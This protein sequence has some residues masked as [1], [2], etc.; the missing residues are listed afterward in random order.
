MFQW[1]FSFFGKSYKF[2]T[3]HPKKRCI[4]TYWNGH[5]LIKADP[6]PIYKKIVSQG[7]LLSIDIK[8]SNSISKE[9][10]NRHTEMVK[11]IRG[12]FEL[13]SFEQGGLSELET[14]QLLDHFMA[15]CT[16]LKKNSNPSVTS[17]TLTEEFNSFSEKDQPTQNSSE[18][19]SIEPEATTEKQ[20]Q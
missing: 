9:A 13:D 20:E 15:F 4:Y 12:I 16:K 19:G 17:S 6:L 7:Q 14:V 2:D 1:L 5:K 11:R 3:Y 10:P 8:I 18:C